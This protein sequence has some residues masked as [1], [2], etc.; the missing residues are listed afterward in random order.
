MLSNRLNSSVVSSYQMHSTFKPADF[1][2]LRP[3]RTRTQRR[4]TRQLL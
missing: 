4:Q 3:E 1:P 2:L